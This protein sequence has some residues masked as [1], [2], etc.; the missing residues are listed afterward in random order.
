MNRNFVKNV[1]YIVKAKWE[2]ERIFVRNEMTV[3]EL[4]EGLWKFERELGLLELEIQEI[5]FWELIRFTIFLELSNQLSGYGQAHT[6]K[7]SLRDKVKA[8]PR[9]LHHSLTKNPFS[10]DHQVDFIVYD[11]ARRVNVE[12]NYIDIYTNDFINAHDEKKFD[13]IEEPYLWQHTT[14]H[15]KKNRKYLDHEMLTVALKKKMSPIRLEHEEKR[16]IEELQQELNKRFIGSNLHLYPLI[17][18]S[19][20]N[21][22]HRFEYHKKL[23]QKR[24]PKTIYVVVSYLK[25]PIIAAAKALGIEVVEFQHGVITKYHLGYNFCN[26][27]IKLAYFPDKLLTFGEYWARTDGFPNQTEIEVVGY[28]Y[29]NKQLERYKGTPKI[30]KQVLFISQGTIGRQLSKEAK[31]GAEV[32]PDYHFVYK[33][34]PG[35]VNRWK[36]EYPNL[37]EASNFSNFDVIDHNEK[38]LYHYLAESE[39]QVGVYSTAIFEGLTLECKTILFNLPGIEYMKDLINQEL[40]EVVRNREEAIQCIKTYKSKEFSSEYFFST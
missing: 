11:H 25:I 1:Y 5:R 20:V 24:K 13:V 31:E 4:C 9:L 29:L 16:L 39:F 37:V 6:N 35:E 22:I 21:F 12:G 10:G 19:L 26:P 40:V 15:V 8:V 32:M 7:N 30:K 33:L 2:A 23:F 36:H 28:P 38:S 27:T 34:H 17:E 14:S 3:E 18:N